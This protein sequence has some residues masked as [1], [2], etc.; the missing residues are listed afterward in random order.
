MQL[1]VVQFIQLGGHG[2]SSVLS[3]YNRRTLTSWHLS[4]NRPISTTF[5]SFCN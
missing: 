4:D 2:V 3:R 5:C 1:S